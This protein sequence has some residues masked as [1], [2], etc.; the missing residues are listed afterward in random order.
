MGLAKFSAQKE[1]KGQ[2]VHWERAHID[3]APFRGRAVMFRNDEE[4]QANTERE[5]DTHSDTFRLWVPEEKAAF[6]KVTEGIMNDWYRLIDKDR[7]YVPEHQSWVWMVVWAEPY[8]VFRRKP[9]EL[10][11]VGMNQ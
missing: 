7:Q 3:G 6:D 11:P 5:N 10:P 1:S 4:Y 8:N 9:G 2:P